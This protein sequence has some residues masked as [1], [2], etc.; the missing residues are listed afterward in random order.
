MFLDDT[1]CNLASLNLLT[2]RDE[3]TGQFQVESYEHAVRLWTVVLEVSVLMAQFPSKQIAERSYEFR[4]LGL[5]YANI[6]GLL[7]TSGIPYDSDAGRAI[8]G[9][10]TAIMT[11]ISYATSAEMAEKLG[12]F[13]GYKKNR[14]HMLRVM[15]NHRRAANGERTGYEKVATPPVPLDHASC[16]DQ[17]LIAHA[18][19]AWDRALSL[20]EKHGYR[21]AQSTVIAPTGT[22]GLV[23]DCDTTGIEPDF[24][25]VKFKKLAGGGYFKIINRAV[26]EALRTL[27]YGEADI[28]EIEA[29]AVG[30][31]TL[32]QAPAINHTTLKAKGFT[33]EAIAKVEKSL[34][35]AFDI[36]FVFNKW[37]LGEDFCRDKLGI[38]AEDLASPTFDLLAAMGFGKREIE[39]A[40][41]HVCGA[42]TVEGAPHL[43]AEHYAVFDCANP[44]GRTGKRYL[45]VES[46]IRMMAAA[47]PFIS[48]AISKTIN[49]PND[50]TVE[51]CKE[52]YL[53]S[54]KLALKANALYRDGSKLSQPLNA[55]L[56]AD[57][58]DE[59]DVVEAFLDR[60][61]AARATGLAEKIVEKIVERV[62]VLR[63]RERMPDRRKGYTQ[64]AVVGG[65]KVY[66]RT[67]EYDDGRLGEI[68]IDMHK[69]GAAL[70]SIINNFAI[71]VSLGLQYGV[72]LEEYVDAF[73]FTRFEPQ[74]PVQ[75]N[76]SI[77]Y[78]T[79]ILDYVFRELAVS[80]LERFDLA[81]VDPSEAGG[82][83][84]LGKGVE[85]GKP[86]PAT[87]YVSKGLTRSRT[88]RL[89]VVRGTTASPGGNITALAAVGGARAEV[90][91]TT[92]LKAEPEAKLSPAEQLELRVDTQDVRAHAK[93][94][95]SEKRAEARAKGYEGEACG[96]CGNFTLVRNGTC[97]KC[98]TCGSTTGCS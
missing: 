66:L 71:A 93:A 46:H 14:E 63:E 35:T 79:S 6:G 88:D 36:K 52:A 7:M 15:R 59:D 25:L 30:H 58:D 28:A 43:K 12:P 45:S 32:A 29:Y 34:P 75:G 84:A 64:K 69:E 82:F 86:T 48:G 8:G 57:E 23:M 76:D 85:E 67:G 92:A 95:A 3:K 55:Q 1:A 39:A 21:N 60:P 96:E 31:G 98:D 72:P 41:V 68:F 27:G 89:S 70:R 53:L 9:A 77:K 73:T 19:A 17:A 50:A 51:D 4:T 94:A 61:A 37:T 10:L 2:F 62:T 20:G 83:D 80:Y 44:C 81:H 40:N 78:A 74:G 90:A 16:P 33:D 47:Q 49:M 5:G 65:H 97:M 54:W 22:I 87:N 24:A 13:P 56:I 18:K 26:P 38:S 11:G 42:M 91:G